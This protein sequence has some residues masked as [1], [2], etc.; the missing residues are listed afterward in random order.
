MNK[1]STSLID[2]I[3][4]AQV[5]AHRIEAGISQEKLWEALGVS[6]QQIQKYEKG[7]NRITASRLVQIAGALGTDVNALLDT[8]SFLDTDQPQFDPRAS[9]L[10]PE[11][12]ELMSTYALLPNHLKRSVEHLCEDLSRHSRSGAGNDQ[13]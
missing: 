12:R 6:F 8:G 1:K 9:L 10:D 4:G 7:V 2:L 13:D 3:I 5:R 11:V